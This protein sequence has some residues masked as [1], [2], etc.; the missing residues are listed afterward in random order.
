MLAAT[1]PMA[2]PCTKRRRERDIPAPVVSVYLYLMLS[3][4]LHFS[5]PGTLNNTFN[6]KGLAPDG[7]I[8]GNQ[9]RGGRYRNEG[10]EL[11]VWGA[12]PIRLVFTGVGRT[13][14][15]SIST[16]AS[17]QDAQ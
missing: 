10:V 15:E 17:A 1:P 16:A 4:P 12:N 6:K 9:A 7:A 14:A 5:A 2:S 13:M 11:V 8:A 3:I